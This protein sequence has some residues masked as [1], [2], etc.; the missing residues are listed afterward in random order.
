MNSDILSKANF[1]WVWYLQQVNMCSCYNYGKISKTFSVKGM[2]HGYHVYQ[3]IWDAQQG[4]RLTCVPEVGNIHD[5]F[6]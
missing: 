4:E 5:L 3:D 6:E 1:V 2:I